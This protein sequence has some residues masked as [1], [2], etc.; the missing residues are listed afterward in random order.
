MAQLLQNES[1]S[2]YDEGKDIDEWKRICEEQGIGVTSGEGEP[3]GPSEVDEDPDDAPQ[4]TNMRAQMK[5]LCQLLKHQQQELK[6]KCTMSTEILGRHKNFMKLVKSLDE[7]MQVYQHAV[8][9]QEPPQQ[10]TI[11]QGQQHPQP[12]TLKGGSDPGN[13]YINSHTAM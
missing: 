3:T 6:E 5:V 10:P 8:A 2:D 12:M 7:D 1:E 4:I 9:Q 11:V 13:Q